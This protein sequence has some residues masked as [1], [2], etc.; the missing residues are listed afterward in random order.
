MAKPKQAIFRFYAELNDFL[1]PNWRQK[2]ITYQFWGNPAVKDA[3]EALGVPHPEIDLI[4]ANNKSVDFRYKL[5][6]KDRIAVYPV[7]ELLDI[8]PLLRLR[9]TPLRQLK[10]IVDVNLG[11]L[12]RYLR[13]LGFDTLFSTNYKDIEIIRIAEKEK[14]LILTRDKELLKNHRVLRGYWVRATEPNEQVKEILKK[15]DL[16]KEIKPFS[17][18][19]ICN[20]ELIKIPKSEIL[21][22]IPPR[23]KQHFN[24]FY[25]CEKCGRIYWPGSHYQ[26]MRKMIDRWLRD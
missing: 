25:H 21:D 26:R 13:L 10:F 3:I 12:A 20:H 4:L 16:S 7:F 2:D 18:C 1:P 19:T 8:R 11:K 6:D 15:F 22:Q 17:R 9:P 24:E 5:K 14:R 23:T